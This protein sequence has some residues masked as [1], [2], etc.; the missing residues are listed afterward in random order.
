M[1]HKSRITILGFNAIATR[2]GVGIVIIS[3]QHPRA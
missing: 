3:V 1:I 2:V